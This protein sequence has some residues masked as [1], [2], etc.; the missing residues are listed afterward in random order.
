M[1]F[2]VFVLVYVDA[3][4]KKIHNSGVVAFDVYVAKDK[5]GLTRYKIDPQSLL[6]IYRGFDPK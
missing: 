2:S 5:D 6:T 4:K 3:K 1:Y